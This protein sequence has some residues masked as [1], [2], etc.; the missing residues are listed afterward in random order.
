MSNA[1]Q[2]L[3]AN[4]SMTLEEL[5][6]IARI[7]CITDKEPS[8]W[9]DLLHRI[10]EILYMDGGNDLMLHFVNLADGKDKRM[11]DIAFDGIGSWKG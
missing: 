7:I 8:N 3:E 11:I 4:S 9:C 5:L 1:S 6:S 10:G 2:I